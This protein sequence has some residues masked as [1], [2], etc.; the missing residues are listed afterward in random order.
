MLNGILTQHDLIEVNMICRDGFARL[1]LN[2]ID[3]SL[4]LVDTLHAYGQVSEI[5][6]Y[7]IISLLYFKLCFEICDSS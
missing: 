2:L 3:F 4:D 7:L 1:S 6:S 5:L